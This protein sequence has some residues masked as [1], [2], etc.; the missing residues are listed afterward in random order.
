M[1]TQKI[2]ISDNSFET[3]FTGSD[4]IYFVNYGD[5]NAR[6]SVSDYS[7]DVNGS[8]NLMRSYGADIDAGDTKVMG[9]IPL[10]EKS[11]GVVTYTV[12]GSKRS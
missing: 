9:G 7:S 12:M 2:A 8:A 5:G 1:V 11:A 6:I 10:P 4:P 3:T